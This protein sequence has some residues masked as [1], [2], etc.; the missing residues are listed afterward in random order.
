M[1]TIYLTIGFVV[2]TMMSFAQQEYSFTH[3]ADVRSV[4]NPASTGTEGFQKITGIF[5][6]QWVGLAGSPMTGGLNYEH[7]LE[8]FNM[9]LGGYVFSDKIGETSL[10][11]V[12]VNYRYSLK[13]GTDHKLAFGLSLGADFINTNNDRLVY[14]DESDPMFNG[15]NYSVVTPRAGL[16]ITYY[17]EKYFLGISVPRLLTF[18]D[19]HNVSI[20]REDMPSLVSHYYLSGGYNFEL[21]NEF[22]LRTIMLGKYTPNVIPQGDINVTAVYRKLVGL[23]LG[24]KSLGFASINAL[25]NYKELFSIGYAFDFTLTRVANYSQGSHEIMLRY[26]FPNRIAKEKF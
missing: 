22:D 17:G 13:L 18:N 5:R 10:T 14:W 23:G 8:K 19:K 7:P 12:V 9:G 4:F 2:T 26:A 3:F 1:K 25:Y 20:D 15:G 11:N 24:Y 16:G 6:K 21:N